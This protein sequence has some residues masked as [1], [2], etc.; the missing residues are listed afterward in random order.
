MRDLATQSL[1]IIDALSS[2]NVP[3]VG[4]TACRACALATTRTRIAPACGPHDAPLFVL[5]E[6]PPPTPRPPQRG[7]RSIGTLIE[8]LSGQG[9]EQG[10]YSH[11]YCCAC[12]TP[13][14]RRPTRAELSSCSRWLMLSLSRVY[15]PR[16][17]LAVGATAASLFYRDNTLSSAIERS[18]VCGHRPQY[19]VANREP[20]YVVPMP[21]IASL[22]AHRRSIDRKPWADIANEQ[23]SIALELVHKTIPASR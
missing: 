4:Q 12:D 5:E 6:S 7:K 2:Q 17:I 13:S 9:V 10:T 23:L 22:S 8:F 11:G 18:A 15:C 1:S 20:L 21:Q 14:N 16:V 19:S 3:N